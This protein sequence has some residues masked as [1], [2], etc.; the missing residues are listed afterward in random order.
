MSLHLLIAVAPSVLT[1]IMLLGN[2]WGTPYPLKTHITSTLYIYE[3]FQHLLLW[4]WV[5]RMQSHT[6]SAWSLTVTVVVVGDSLGFSLV[7]CVRL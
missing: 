3:V 7:A 6:E 5:I 2:D 4:L 1:C